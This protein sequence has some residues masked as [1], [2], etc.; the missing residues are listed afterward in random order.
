[1]SLYVLTIILNLKYVF[2]V[3][4]GNHAKYCQFLKTSIVV[5]F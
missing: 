4:F 2:I 5:K 1:M 3:Y